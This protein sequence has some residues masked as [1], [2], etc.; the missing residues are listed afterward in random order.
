MSVISQLSVRPSR[1]VAMV[2]FIPSYPHKLGLINL[3][4]SGLAPYSNRVSIRAHNP[5]SN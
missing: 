3:A 4:I 2:I 1:A 5:D